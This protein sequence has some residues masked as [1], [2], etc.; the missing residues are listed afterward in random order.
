MMAGLSAIDATGLVL[1][2]VNQNH[3]AIYGDEPL[4]TLDQLQTGIR[5]YPPSNRIDQLFAAIGGHTVLGL[6]GDD[7]HNAIMSGEA[8]AAEWP[9]A[10]ATAFAGAACRWPRT[11][12][13]S[14]S[15]VS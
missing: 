6:S 8:L 7:W 1:A 9:T 5:C 11:S 14:T 12:R 15:S 13:S 3:L 10:L 2:P 4:R